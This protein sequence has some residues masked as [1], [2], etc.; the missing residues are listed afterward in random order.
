[1]IW[2]EKK[3]YNRK[4]DK[5]KKEMVKMRLKNVIKNENI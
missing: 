5:Q 1:M 3:I 4:F 2:N